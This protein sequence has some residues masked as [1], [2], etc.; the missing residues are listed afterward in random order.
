MTA[1]SPLSGVADRYASALFEL[2]TSAA[3]IKAAEKDLD[4]LEKA[5][6]ESTDLTRLIKSPVFASDEQV[7]AIDAIL[8]KSKMG[9]LTANFIRVVARN[10]RLFVLPTMIDSF[11]AMAADAR[12]EVA[13]DV[14]SAQKLTADQ[15]KEL[16]A[17]LKAKIGK[18]VTL[19]EI[20]EPSILGGLIVKVGSRMIDTS[21]RT[22]LNSLKTMMKEVG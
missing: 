11:R 22:K 6:A 20:V 8:K 21:I 12:G 15:R 1:S 7:K 9:N 3:K 5:L 16:K 17:A 10:R 4:G 19:H 2:C 18:D 13:G 14:T